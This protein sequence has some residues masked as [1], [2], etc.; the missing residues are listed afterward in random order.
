MGG[1]DTSIYRMLQPPQVSD[2]VQQYERALQIKSIIGQQALQQ[3]QQ[4]SNEIGIQQQQQSQQDQQAMTTAMQ[5]WDGADYTQLPTLILKNG[6]SANAVY[7]AVQHL[8]DMK[9]KASEIAKNDAATNASNVESTIKNQDQY[10][11]R[12]QAIINAPDDQKQQLWDSEITKEEQA[13]TIKPG[14]V[15]H[16]YPGDD[17]AT[18]FANHYALGS[19]LVKEADE[20]Q[21]TA[22]E[23]WKPIN[24]QLVNTQTGEKIGANLNVPQLNKALE[25]RYQVLNPGQPLP[26]QF[27]LQP[28]A[29][30]E[31]FQRIDKIL[32][33]SEKAAGTKAQQET[34]NAIRTQT[35]DLA[36]DKQDLNPVVGTDPK[37]GRAILAPY[38]QAQQMGLQNPMKAD[39]DMVNKA[40]AARHWLQLA[41]G[42][43]DPNAAPEDM[44]IMQLIDKLDGEG[45]LGPLAG[46]WNDFM[47]GKFGA[48]D[49]EYAA[50]RAKMGL[51]TTLLMQAHVGSRG[52]SALLEHFEDLAN[53]RRM[54]G[55]TLKAAMGAE[56]N[57]VTDKAMDPNAPAVRKPA[58]AGGPPAGATMKVPGSDGKL[59]WSDGKRD[60]GVV[61]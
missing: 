31:D 30:P 49:P 48:G 45:K 7:T 15:S 3:Q 51:S 12:L 32:E 10:R 44:G 50:L 59:H 23:S 17:Q 47:S 42:Q 52:G 13:G 21:K 28:N 20:K 4:R 40:T 56:V 22:N 11:G 60:L 24:G 19:Q 8:Q 27:T 39:A 1:I 33:A 26:P 57:Y 36:R 61:Q 16:Q 34:A 46:R 37:T 58:S 14:T 38:S 6:G 43:A 9:Q 29:T 18:V 53:A 35:F 55:P 25:A 54:D 5:Q 41:N 2:P